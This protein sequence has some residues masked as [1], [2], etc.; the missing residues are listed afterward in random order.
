[1][2]STPV[3]LPVYQTDVYSTLG[4]MSTSSRTTETYDSYGN[5]TSASQYD[6][7]ATSPS[8]ITTATYG[9]YSNGHCTPIGNYISDRPCEVTVSDGTKTLSDVR[10]TYDTK[11]NLIG[12]SSLVS[13]NTWLITSAT[14]NSNGTTNTA[15]DS[16]SNVTTYGYNG[17]GGCNSS[18]PTSVTSGGMTSYTTWDCSGGVKMSSIDPNGSTTTYSYVN[19]TTGL[20]DP[21]WRLIQLTFSDGGGTTT[22]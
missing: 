18:L 10:I 6:F 4:G 14:H 16:N 21:F 13:G 20:A 17:S 11:G 19:P 7:G 3:Q 2:S 5:I 12:K 9:S 8:E 22:T 15:T 1:V